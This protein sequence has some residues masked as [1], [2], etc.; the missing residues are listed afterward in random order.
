VGRRYRRRPDLDSPW[1]WLGA[2]LLIY[3]YAAILALWFVW[4]MIA[5]PIAGVAKIRHNDDLADK[6][7]RSL[8]CRGSSRQAPRRR[9]PPR[10]Y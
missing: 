3:V 6:M 8:R 4:A 9:P 1:F 5:L 10:R 7:V 2:L